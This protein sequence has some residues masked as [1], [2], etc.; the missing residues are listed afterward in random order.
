M[1]GVNE[2]RKPCLRTV[3]KHLIAFIFEETVGSGERPKD[4]GV[5]YQPL[6]GIRF[7]RAVKKQRTVEAS[8]WVGCVFLPEGQ[9]ISHQI[10]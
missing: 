10:L 3:G 1:F 6:L 7:G 5:Q 4:T 9:D 2:M 8:R